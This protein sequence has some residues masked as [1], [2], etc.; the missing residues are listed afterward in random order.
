MKLDFSEF[1]AQY[2]A[3]V[4][5]VDSVFDRVADM[6][7]DCIS[8]KTGCSDCCHALFDVSLIEALY[9][10]HKFL[11]RYPFGEERSNIV[12]AANIADRKIYKRKRQLY[13]DS[14]KGVETR[15]LLEAMAKER[16]RCPL[17]NSEEKCTLYDARPITCRLYG[18]PTNIGGKAH[19]C[20]LSKF[21]PGTPYPTVSLDTIQDRL[22]KI[23]LELCKSIKSRYKELPE[24]LVPV[25]MALITNY[26]D[27]YLGLK[28]PKKKGV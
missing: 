5:E 27:E 16:I 18:I 10:N 19:T 12:E 9:L 17:L 26:D 15:E 28:E 21:K 2:E 3:L 6:H 20:G 1:F 11:E 4:A 22:G 13:R 24:V 25:S 23:S 14:M 7:G 8:C